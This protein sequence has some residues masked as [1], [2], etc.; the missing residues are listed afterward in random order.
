MKMCFYFTGNNSE[1]RKNKCRKCAPRKSRYA[2]PTRATTCYPLCTTFGCL[3]PWIITHLRD[4]EL[5][6]VLFNFLEFP[7]ASASRAPTPSIAVHSS[8]QKCCH[9]YSIP[10]F[11]PIKQT[12]WDPKRLLPNVDDDKHQEL[13]NLGREETEKIPRCAF[14]VLYLYCEQS[15]N[16]III[17]RGKGIYLWVFSAGHHGI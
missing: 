9:P 3:F 5:H 11:W 15:W 12:F 16:K 2:P 17:V 8:S 14:L 4:L 7:P 10:N 6:N 1:L 13:P